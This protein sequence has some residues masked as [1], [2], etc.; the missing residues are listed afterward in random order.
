MVKPKSA[1]IG[2]VAGYN[3]SDCKKSPC[4]NAKIDRCIPQPGQSIPVNDLNG[5]VI[6]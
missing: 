5:Q 1:I 3:F 4:N 2:I 6:R